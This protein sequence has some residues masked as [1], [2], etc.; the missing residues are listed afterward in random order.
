MKF[1]W[2]V[3]SAAFKV[4]NDMCNLKKGEHL[5]IYAD[6]KVDQDV[7][8]AIAEAG[9]VAGGEVG[10]YLYRTREEVGM[11]P[12]PPLREAMKAS[13]I[14]IEL[15]EKYLIHT[16]AYHDALDNGSR[17]LCLTGMD[18]DMLTRCIG[19][20]N[21]KAMVEFGDKL[22][23]ILS[24]GNKMEITT[25][26]GTHLVSEIGRRPFYH[27]S[28]IID[29]PGQQSFL[30]GQI[31]WAPVEETINGTMVFDGSVWPPDELGL[32]KEPI[33]MKVEKGR[34]VEI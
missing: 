11:E 5:L 8:S 26:A 16:K 1:D 10:V 24:R 7:L 29:S 4:I 30:G 2:E 17:N 12:P 15:A 27:N 33:V 3:K 20:I 19:D 34:V 18:K 23:E 6:T 25:P 21:Y 9:H 14:I 32:L 22:M 31:S 28:G 13:D